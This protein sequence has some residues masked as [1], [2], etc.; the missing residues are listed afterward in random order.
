M[1]EDGRILTGARAEKRA[2][3]VGEAIDKAL[4]DERLARVGFVVF[5]FDY[6][7]GLSL[8]YQINVSRKYVIG[9]MKKFIAQAEAADEPR[10]A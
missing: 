4:K 9:Q 5:L 10:K 6:E 8:T 7:L 1:S 3:A 2:K